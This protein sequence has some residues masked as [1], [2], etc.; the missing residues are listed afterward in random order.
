MLILWTILQK[1][2]DNI[3]IDQF[4]LYTYYS[5]ELKKIFQDYGMNLM[6]EN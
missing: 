2:G 1:M 3:I 6:V 5:R 4:E